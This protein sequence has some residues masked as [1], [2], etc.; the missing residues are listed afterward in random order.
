MKT[1][2]LIIVTLAFSLLYGC[3]SVEIYSDAGLKSKTGLKFY[4]AK[5][6]LLVELKSEKD[7]TVKTTV[8]YLPDLENPQYISVLP[9]VGSSELKMAFTNG[10]LNSYGLTNDTKTAET[11]NSLS[12]FLAKSADA[13]KQSGAPVIPQLLNTGEEVFKLYEIVFTT[14]GTKLKEVTGE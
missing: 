7:M 13:L 11:I 8:I 3:A 2:N 1:I 6:Y 5:P 9:G 14:E 4:T 10:I 12:G